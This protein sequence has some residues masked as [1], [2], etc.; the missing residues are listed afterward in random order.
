[1]DIVQVLRNH[2]PSMPD[3]G[4]FSAIVDHV[5]QQLDDQELHED[6]CVIPCIDLE[7]RVAASD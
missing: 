3:S 1:M 5:E 6:Q 2:I 4:P 7:G